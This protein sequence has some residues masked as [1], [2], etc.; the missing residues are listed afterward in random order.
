MTEEI[1]TVNKDM[2]LDCIRALS[3]FIDNSSDSFQNI[4]TSKDLPPD[5][6]R[7]ILK[8]LRSNI[9]SVSAVMLALE[10]SM[11]HPQQINDLKL[12]N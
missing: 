3:V 6:R 8:V 7:V 1:L 10:A 12:V 2:F 4:K 5:T 9:E 11:T